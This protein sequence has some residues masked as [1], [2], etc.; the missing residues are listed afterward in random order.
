MPKIPSSGRQVQEG[1]FNAPSVRTS[2]QPVQSNIA[3]QASGVIDQAHGLYQEA[4]Q[5]NLQADTDDGVNKLKNL[6]NKKLHGDMESGQVGY[7]GVKGK[8]TVTGYEQYKKEFDEEADAIIQEYGEDVRKQLANYKGKIGV[9]YDKQ[10][11]IH[12]NKEMENHY[13]EQTQAN[14]DTLINDSA[15]NYDKRGANG[16]LKAHNNIK[17]LHVSIYGEEKDGQLTK[18]FMQN[19]RITKD[20]AD[21]IY[22]NAASKLHYGVIARAS[23]DGRQRIAQSYYDEALKKKEITASDALRLDKM[24]KSANTRVGSQ[25]AVDDVMSQ[26]ASG[27]IKNEFDARDYI[28]KNY[29]GE[30]E[31]Q[32]IQD[33]N[34]RQSEGKAKTDFFRKESFN[35]VADEIANDPESFKFNSDHFTTF[36]AEEQKWLQNYQSSLIK[37]K[38]GAKS[39]IKTNW[40][41]YNRLINERDSTT[42]ESS[43]ILK[44]HKNGNLA[45]G[46]TKELLKLVRANNDQFKNVQTLNSFVNN[47]VADAGVSGSL[48]GFNPIPEGAHQDEDFVRSLFNTELNKYPAEERAKLET[49]EEIKKKILKPVSGAGYYNEQYWKTIQ[50]NKQVKPFADKK[51][52]RGNRR[53]I[54]GKWYTGFERALPNGDIEFKDGKGNTIIFERKK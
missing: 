40:N 22:T 39:S 51:E 6:Y 13:K 24:M 48:W 8:E 34:R 2:F 45:I 53:K 26:M 35:G 21:Q 18:G 10:L 25:E 17:A 33:F 31:D 28:R 43:E 12:S 52:Y 4:K 14:I 47:T 5:R 16:Q 15:L 46:E 20:Q 3:K 49:W 7:Y 27:K 19:A 9:D 36:E 50:E 42:L 54:D 38:Y 30:L 11:N 44:E 23:N 37:Q 32:A 29:S 41:V 1:V